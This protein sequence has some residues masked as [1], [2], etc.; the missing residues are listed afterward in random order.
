MKAWELMYSQDI[1]NEARDLADD[2]KIVKNDGVEIVGEIDEFEVSTFIEYNSP[3]HVSCSCP[4]WSPCKHEAGFIYYLEK[5]PELCISKSNLN[6]LIDSVNSDDLKK[7]LLDEMNNNGEFKK[8]FLNVFY[9]S[10]SVDKTAYKK[11]LSGIFKKGEGRDFEYH[12]FYELKLMESDLNDFLT[13]DI[14]YLLTVGEFD[15]ACDLLI[16]I[17]GLLDDELMS[18]QDAW[19]DLSDIFMHYVHSLSNSIH[20][21]GDKMNKLYSKTGLITDLISVF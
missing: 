16:K 6:D 20:L 5:H 8:K 14:N 4:L 13:E 10:P 1:L 21:D 2:V 18:C 17:G 9:E 7:F 15:F 11:R 19:Y 3:S 12:G